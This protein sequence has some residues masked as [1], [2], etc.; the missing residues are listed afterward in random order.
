MDTWRDGRRRCVHSY[1]TPV[2]TYTPASSEAW[3]FAGA[4]RWAT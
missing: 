1:I 2:L 3:V 4:E